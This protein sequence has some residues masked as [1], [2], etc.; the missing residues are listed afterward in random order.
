MC[1]YPRLNPGIPKYDIYKHIIEFTPAEINIAEI[2]TKSIPEQSWMTKDLKR[3]IDKHK[4]RDVE[5]IVIKLMEN[6]PTEIQE[7][8]DEVAA[9]CRNL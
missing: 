7:L 9:L 6:A 2:P 8:D 5:E 4:C 1:Y 3:C